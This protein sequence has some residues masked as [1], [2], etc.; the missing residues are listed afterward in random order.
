MHTDSWNNWAGV[1]F[2][3]PDAPV[4]AGTGLYV[5]QDG[6][7][8]AEDQLE[9]NNEVLINKNTQDITKWTLVDRVGNVFNRLVL[10]NARQFHSSL[11]YFVDSKENGRLFQTFFFSTER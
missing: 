3:T 7:R 6:T 10:F 11:D 4:S 2:L 9:K 8:F 1:L 5:F